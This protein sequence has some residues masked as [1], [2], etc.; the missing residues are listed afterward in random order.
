MENSK[1][2]SIISKG[3]YTPQLESDA[4]GT[5]L[6]A[7]LKGNKSHELI[8]Q[9]LQMLENMEHRGACGCEPNTG[10]G[11]G[12]L[13]QIPH[14][15]FQTKVK[16]LG[17]S[18]PDMGFYGVG[19]IFF[20]KDR[21]L[22]EQCRVLL[23]DYIDECDFELLGYRDVPTQNESL[24]DSALKVEPKIEQVFVKP[25]S[26]L[27]KKSLERKL[28][29]LRKFATHNIYHT[30]PQA[31]DHFYVLLFLTRPLFTKVS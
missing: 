3:L 23:N 31:K 22:R 11:A 5:G 12:I 25:K 28:Y 21:V 13:I 2:K 17:F 26:A 30:Y 6:I 16:E 20:P 19:M 24:G 14:L 9:A 1:I 18:L 29:I 27:D 10:D 15:F 7:N 8:E 4:C